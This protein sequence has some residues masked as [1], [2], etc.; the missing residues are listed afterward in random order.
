[1]K[2][3]QGFR[4]LLILFAAALAA[5]LAA[6]VALQFLPAPAPAAPTLSPD[7]FR[8]LTARLA[9]AGLTGQAVLRPDRVLA[10]EVQPPAAWPADQAPQAVWAVFDAVAL[11]PPCCS[12]YPLEVV[13][14]GESHHVRARVSPADLRAWAQGELDDRE[15]VERVLYVESPPA[16][17][18][19]E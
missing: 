1:M 12:V 2:S 9:Q 15:L 10:V 11:L 17:L 4:F 16:S 7:C 19:E 8:E 13:V 6:T 14:S 3:A 18:L 5:W